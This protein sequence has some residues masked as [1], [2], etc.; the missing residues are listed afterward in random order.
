MINI[1]EYLGFD[2]IEEDTPIEN[3]ILLTIPLNEKTIKINAN[4]IDNLG[5]ISSFSNKED[6]NYINVILGIFFLS[7]A[8]TFMIN[9]IKILKKIYEKES[10]YKTELKEILTKYDDIIVEVKKIVN[11]KDY[12]LIYVSN[13][14]ELLD[15][16][17][18]NK[19]IINYKETKKNIES[20]FV[21]I[22]EDNAWIYKLNNERM[23]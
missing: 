3:E 7:L 13:F 16:H 6:I 9:V 4:N 8:I 2:K 18:I 11:V 1:Y 21:I 17:E 22:T 14:K 12:N 23:P 10:K 15:V 19:G 20:I 5:S